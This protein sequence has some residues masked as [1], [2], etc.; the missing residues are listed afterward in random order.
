M[1]V[2]IE[3]IV[4]WEHVLD[5]AR[6]TVGKPEINKE[7]SDIF[8]AKILISEHSPIRKLLYEITWKSIPYWV[9]MHFR[10]HHMGFKSAEDDLYFVQTQRSDRT[11]HERDK[12]PQDAPVLLRAQ[13]NAQ[14]IIN[15]SRVR[16]CHLTALETRLA[17]EEMLVELKRIDPVLFEVCVPNCIYRGFCPEAQSCGF[18]KTSKYE[19]DFSAYRSYTLSLRVEQ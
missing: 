12:L 18:N 11:Q 10:T 1:S 6:A 16:L 13:M 7:P 19:N 14:S 9:A 2:N 8:K 5:D 3:R 17:W 4:G 15:V